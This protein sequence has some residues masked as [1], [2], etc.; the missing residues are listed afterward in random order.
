M[1]GVM[2][3]ERV[4]VLAAACVAGLGLY[5]FQF[6][7]NPTRGYIPTDSLFTW[8][9]VQWFNPGS[10]AEHGPL[11]VAVSLWLFVRNLR[12]GGESSLRFSAASVAGWALA[13]GLAVHLLGYLAQQARISI[14]GLLIYLWGGLTLWGGGRWGRAA[15]FPVAFLVFAI[16]VSFLDS[17]GFYLRLWVAELAEAISPWL[18]W[19]VVRNGTHLASGDGAY[20][21][22]VA[23]ACSG[24][25]SLVALTA[26]SCLAGYGSLRTPGARLA[27][28][29]SALPFAFAGN[30]VR[31]F[32]IVLA[33]ELG[34]EA[35]GLRVHDLSGFL[36]FVV[37]LLLL[38]GAIRLLQRTP[39]ERRAEAAGG[40]PVNSPPAVLPDRESILRVA[41][42][43]VVLG[44]V[45]LYV[46]QRTEGWAVEEGAGVILSANGVDPVALPRILSGG[47]VGEAVPV[48][49]V[50]REILPAGTGF[51]RINYVRATDPAQQVFVS[52]VLS[53]ADRTSIHRPELC[54]V[55]QG[56]S[57]LGRFPHRFASPGLP[58]DEL[59][60]TVLR[61]RREHAE[62]L[63]RRVIPGVFAYWF[64]GSDR[65]VA[66][67]GQRMWWLAWD[68]LVR[69]RNH[70]WAYVVAQT[71]ALDGEEAA[72]R[73]M[74]DVLARV[75]PS[76][77]NPGADTL[78]AA[79]PCP[80]TG[81]A[82]P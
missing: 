16:P 77:H 35:L 53:G 13:G 75:L 20:Q 25:R 24:I 29:A 71:H 72:L 66:S 43:T 26:L 58:L 61:V 64:V 59:P 18:G 57:I 30:L 50:E 31:I 6:H 37:V 15:A 33:A 80:R 14:I 12:G 8:W 32:A 11:I 82:Y 46:Q 51:S 1:S 44:L 48:S 2:P 39:W 74:Q 23:A 79:E 38:L 60:A 17:L 62:G 22:D 9:G 52:I 4:R 45:V 81:T 28:L 67:H 63:Q 5:L 47:W 41:G 70:R 34:G 73:R 68:R 42:L 19:D 36:V 56:W 54:L 69:R 21:Y 55:G 3:G 76:F 27:V 10:E 65:V 78:V 7:G 40:E 49:A